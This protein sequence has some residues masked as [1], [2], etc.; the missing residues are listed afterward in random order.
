M[1]SKAAY[2]GLPSALITGCIAFSIRSPFGYGKI[3]EFSAVL[4][5]VQ[6]GKALLGAGS[7][8]V[9]DERKEASARRC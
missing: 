3:M 6:S 2:F 4:S 8:I 9:T 7:I 5:Y 1:H